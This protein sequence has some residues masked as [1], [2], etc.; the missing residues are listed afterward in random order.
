MGSSRTQA[1]LRPYLGRAQVGLKPGSGWLDPSLAQ[2]G[3]R[4]GS[5]RTKAEPE[6]GSVRTKAGLRSDPGQAQ[7]GPRLGSGLTQAG[8]R[9][10]PGQAQVGPGPGSGRTQTGVRSYPGR[11]QVRPGPGSG[12]T[13]SGLGRPSP[14]SDGTPWHRA[15]V[16]QRRG[17]LDNDEGPTT[18]ISSR[19]HCR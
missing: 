7:V 16:S 4:P 11:A 12:R 8:L 1:W 14:V 6:S 15:S 5:G 9:S 18:T 13:Q 3:P 10:D 19:I 17:G 2:V